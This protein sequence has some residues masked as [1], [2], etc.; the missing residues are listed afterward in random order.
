MSHPSEINSSRKLLIFWCE[1]GD[2]NSHVLSGFGG[3]RGC[4][5]E[6]DL[7]WFDGLAWAPCNL[8]LDAAQ[9]IAR[10]L[11]LFVELSSLLLSLEAPFFGASSWCQAEQLARG[12]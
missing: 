11:R 3:I 5:G 9:L 12:L 8:S 10:G 2:P 1:R 7:G 4:V 6:I